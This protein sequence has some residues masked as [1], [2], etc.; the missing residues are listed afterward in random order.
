MAKPKPTA[1]VDSPTK[2][3]AVTF[4]VAADSVRDYMQAVEKIRAAETKQRDAGKPTVSL[5]MIL[6]KAAVKAAARL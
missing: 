1:Q 2:G 4:F 6:V 5:S 3:R